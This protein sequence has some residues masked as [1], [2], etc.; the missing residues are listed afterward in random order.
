MPFKLRYDGTA[1]GHKTQTVDTLRMRLLRNIKDSGAVSPGSLVVGVSGGADSVCLLHL[2]ASSADD[3][4]VRL[5]AAHLD[6]GMR[7]LES[8]ADRQYVIGLCGELGVPLTAEKTDVLLGK[9]QHSPAEE[10]AR[11]A[12]Y[13]FFARVCQDVGASA[14]AVGHTL[15]DHLETVLLHLLRGS[16]MQGLGGLE[17][18]TTWQRGTQHVEVVRPLLAVRRAETEEYCRLFVLKPRQDSSNLSK[19]PLRNRIRL[20]LL[21]LLRQYA[22]GFDA[23]LERMSRLAHDEY[24]AIENWVQQAW[25]GAVHISEEGLR[26]DKAKLT[27]YPAGLRRAVLRRSLETVLGG[28]RDIEAVHVEAMMQALSMPAGNR[29]DLLKG[30]VLTVGYGSIELGMRDRANS[31]PAFQGVHTLNIPG[32]TAIGGWQVSAEVLDALA[33]EERDTEQGG[34]VAFID[35]DSLRG[36]LTVR[37]RRPGDKFQP[38]GMSGMKKL[39]DFMVDER[40]PRHMR[41]TVPLVCSQEG[42]IWVVG[43][44]LDERARVT[45]E[46]QKVLKLAFRIAVSD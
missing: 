2:L 38:M 30:A 39:Q 26:L 5:H 29:I 9:R 10:A 13:S 17:P 18:R 12:R 8:D 35:Q 32:E 1:V 40:I 42:V 27:S 46:T 14:V 3:L 23:V 37:S 4:H 19:G 16:G 20:E 21:P 31:P 6:H 33:L 45:R 24:L 25:P 15:D 43:Y 41:D 44:R 7:G 22:P 34:L 28:M 36:P 11:E